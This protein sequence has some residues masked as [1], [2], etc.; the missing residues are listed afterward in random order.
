MINVQVIKKSI[1]KEKR[2]ISINVYGHSGYAE[3]G[4]DIVCASVSSVFNLVINNIQQDNYL[5]TIDENEGLGSI[6]CKSIPSERDD[7][8]MKCFLGFIENLVKQY[9]KY[10]SLKIDVLTTKEGK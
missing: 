6:K 3:K 4:S 1:Q 8:L 7:F 2:I 5:I 9:D 10:V